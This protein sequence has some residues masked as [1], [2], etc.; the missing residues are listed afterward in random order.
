MR[1]RIPVAMTLLVLAATGANAH[2]SSLRESLDA[3]YA[4]MKSAMHTHDTRMLR[5]ILAPDFVSVELNGKTES[6]DQMIQ[7]IKALPSDASRSS[8]TTLLSI[9]PSKTRAVV[10]QQYTMRT[11]REGP[12]GMEH[13]IKLITVSTDTW[14]L[15]RGSWRI[16]RTVTNQ[17]DYYLDGKHVLHQKRPDVVSH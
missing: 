12:N 1:S 4:Q 6:A 15:L 3:R 11:K 5:A 8:R 10:E 7:E 14:V 17:L 16:Q 9:R 13:N 2:E